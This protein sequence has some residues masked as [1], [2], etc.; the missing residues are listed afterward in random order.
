VKRRSGEAAPD[1]TEVAR[2]ASSAVQ[3]RGSAV[4][5]GGTPQ[6]KGV[7]SINADKCPISYSV[8]RH[9]G[10]WQWQWWCGPAALHEYLF[11]RHPP[12]HPASTWIFIGYS[13]CVE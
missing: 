13:P 4:D 6:A 5:G 12:H 11:F 7:R 8:P 1:I 9:S 3:G 10:E 2:F